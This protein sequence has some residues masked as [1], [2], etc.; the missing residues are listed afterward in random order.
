VNAESPIKDKMRERHGGV[1]YAW[2][3]DDLRFLCLDMYPDARTREWLRG[4]L[5][6]AGR[7]RPLILFFHYSLEGPYS[8]FWKDEEKDAFAQALQGHNVLAI[9]HGHEHRVGHYLWH[10]HPVF[11]PGA[12]RHASHFFLVVRVGPR[13]ME[14][15]AW[16]FDEGGWAESWAV[17][18]KR[19]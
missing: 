1:D 4:E 19:P 15:T 8:G 12:P 3:W 9:F 14:V 17:P 7:R 10:G 18:V 11:R 6:R 2:D 16:N 13:Q 5:E